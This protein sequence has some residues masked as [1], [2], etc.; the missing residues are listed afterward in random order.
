M[1]VFSASDCNHSCSFSVKSKGTFC[2]LVQSDDRKAQVS[3]LKVQVGN[4]VRHHRETV[5]ITQANLAERTERS[6]QLIGRIERGD[7]APS[8]ETLEA[9]AG[10]LN[11]DVRDLFGV[12]DYA[13]GQEI[14][15]GPLS[16]LIGKVAKLDADDLEWITS[17]VELALS[18][19]PSRRAA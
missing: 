10:A 16:R 14:D 9:I 1:V 18:R 4:L 17:L 15:N 12:G 5:G 2:A 11:V 13:A 6:V 3:N 19:K 8:F 7:T